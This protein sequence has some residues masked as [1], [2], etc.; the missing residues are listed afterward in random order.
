MQCFYFYFI[1][2]ETLIFGLKYAI[3]RRMARY[4]ECVNYIV[5]LLNPLCNLYQIIRSFKNHTRRNN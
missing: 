4:A 3:A 2:P 1:S 5:T